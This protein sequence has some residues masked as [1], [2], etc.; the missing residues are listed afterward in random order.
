MTLEDAK[1]LADMIESCSLDDDDKAY[2]ADYADH[3]WPQWRWV[4]TYEDDYLTGVE[5]RPA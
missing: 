4:A 1:K 5:V 2:L 3:Y